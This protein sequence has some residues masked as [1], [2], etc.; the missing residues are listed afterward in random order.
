MK[1]NMVGKSILLDD[2]SSASSMSFGDDRETVFADSTNSKF[3]TRIIDSDLRAQNIDL[4]AKDN[5]VNDELTTTTLLDGDA[6]GAFCVGWLLC[7]SGPMK[8]NSYTLKTGRNS[9][10]RS[11]KNAVC[12]MND[13]SIS[14]E[15]QVYVVY[16]EE[17]NEYAVVPGSGSAIS[18]LNKKRLDQSTG[19]VLGDIITLSPQTSLRFVPACDESFRW[20]S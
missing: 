15:A 20:K 19:L 6:E 16:D 11:A 13:D 12:L 10:G 14:R 17:E 3:D 9:V 5:P 7:I 18:R 4:N 1:K 2:S 8:G